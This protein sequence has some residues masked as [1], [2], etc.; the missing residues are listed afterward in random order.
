MSDHFGECQT[1]RYWVQDEDDQPSE[2]WGV[3]VLTLQ[4]TDNARLKGYPQHHPSSL[5]VAFDGADTMAGLST[6]AEFGCIQWREDTREAD[7]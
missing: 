2:D 1:C 7:R 3:C 4:S 6:S 5:A